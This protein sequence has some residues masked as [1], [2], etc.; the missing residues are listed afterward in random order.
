MKFSTDIWVA[1]LIRRVELGGG[2]AVLAHKGDARA[3][4]VLVKVVN[5][6][7]GQV[8]LF[9]EATRADGETVWMRPSRAVHEADLDTYIARARRIDPDLWVVE[10]EDRQGRHFLTE[11]VEEG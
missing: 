5:R 3:G 8:R 1:A 6:S 7:S 11:D 10:I 4:S 9:A 2:F